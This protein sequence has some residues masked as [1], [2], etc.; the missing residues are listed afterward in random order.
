MIHKILTDDDNVCPHCNQRGTLK[1][2]K[3]EDGSFLD[4]YWCENDYKLASWNGQLLLGAD[5][6]AFPNRD[7]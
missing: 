6:E 2:Y 5:G 4:L 3:E 7:K 1:Y